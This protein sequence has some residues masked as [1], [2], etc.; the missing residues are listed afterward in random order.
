MWKTNVDKSN[1]SIYGQ[2]TKKEN[3]PPNLCGKLCE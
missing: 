2:K 3:F 1:I